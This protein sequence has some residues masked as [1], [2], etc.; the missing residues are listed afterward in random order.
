MGPRPPVPG[1]CRAWLWRN[2]NQG[3]PLNV[4]AVVLQVKEM[5]KMGLMGVDVPVEYGLAVLV[6]VFPR[7]IIVLHRRVWA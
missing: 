4:F 7:L 1:Q 3:L 6:F 2:C 5:G